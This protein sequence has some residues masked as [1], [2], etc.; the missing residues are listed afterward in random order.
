MNWS[1]ELTRYDYLRP[2]KEDLAPA[3]RFLDYNIVSNPNYIVSL[4]GYILCTEIQDWIDL[5]PGHE[6]LMIKLPPGYGKTEHAIRRAISYVFGQYPFSAQ[7]YITYGDELSDPVSEETRD[8]MET[9]EYQGIFPLVE[10]ETNKNK[11]WRTNCGGRLRATGIMGSFVGRHF[12]RIYIDDLFKNQEEAD[13][14]K[15]RK[16]KIR[17]LQNDVFS[18]EKISRKSPRT[19]KL[20]IGTQRHAEDQF[21]LAEKEMAAGGEQWRIVNIPAFHDETSHP[22][23]HPLDTREIGEPLWLVKH[24]YEALKVIEARDKAGFMATFQQRPSNLNGDVIKTDWFEIV[25]RA[26]DTKMHNRGWCFPKLLSRCGDEGHSTVLCGRDAKRNV[27][28]LDARRLETG[29]TGGIDEMRRKAKDEK[30]VKLRIKKCHGRDEIK[31]EIKRNVPFGRFLKEVD[32]AQ[33][34]AWTTL[35]QQGRVKLVKGDWNQTFLDAC[36]NYS[37]TGQ[38][39]LESLIHAATA[40]I[41]GFKWSKKDV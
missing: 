3:E 32:A 25:D 18:R 7:L 39:R 8:I 19:P 15:I 6:N 13:S 22:N 10:P 9:P 2:S 37:D 40:A 41:L 12:D 30:K 38:D 16:K 35:A 26:P 33:P 23:R 34:L 11:E 31:A 20:M 36:I 4:H 28:I 27:Y 17:V 1:A 14:P 5:V 24:T 21:G 29:F